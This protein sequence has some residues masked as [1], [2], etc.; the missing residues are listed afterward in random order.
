MS[1]RTDAGGQDMAMALVVSFYDYEDTELLFT[2][3][4][5]LKWRTSRTLGY[6]RAASISL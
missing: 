5:K 2:F 3:V 1:T 6:S 4:F